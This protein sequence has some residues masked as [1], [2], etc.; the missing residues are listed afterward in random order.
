MMDTTIKVFVSSLGAYNDGVLTGQWTTL[1][2]DDVK[3]EILDKIKGAEGDEYFISDYEAPFKIDEYED[4][5]DL[6]KAAEALKNNGIKDL[7]GLYDS[8]DYRGFMEPEP[9]E[10]D[11]DNLNMILSGRSPYDVLMACSTNQFNLN[12]ELVRLNSLNQLESMDEDEWNDE[13]KD[14]A[15]EML[16]EF[17]NENQVYSV[18]EAKEA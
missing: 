10:N 18:D 16:K 6:N 8:L 3:K 1:P 5:D 9:I 14:H 13:L 7:Q 2:V 12:N 11:E 15:D 17:I 4:L